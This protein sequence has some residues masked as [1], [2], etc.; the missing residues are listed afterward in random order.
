MGLSKAAAP[1]PA[2]EPG[3]KQHGSAGGRSTGGRSTGG[4]KGS[5]PKP[6][7]SPLDP[8]LLAAGLLSEEEGSSDEDGSEE[9]SSEEESSSEEGSEEGQAPADSGSRD[10]GRR[11][12]GGSKDVEEQQTSVRP[13]RTGRGRGDDVAR[14]R[15]TADQLVGC[16]SRPCQEGQGQPADGQRREA[17]AHPKQQGQGQW[18]WQEGQR[19]CPAAGQGQGHEEEE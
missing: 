14:G 17:Q 13:A 8:L 19:G 3:D 9:G 4:S 10:D 16:S 2:Q 7:S 5:Q 15:V 11:A 6:A 18:C 1:T 12:G